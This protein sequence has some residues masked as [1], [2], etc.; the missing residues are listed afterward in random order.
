MSDIVR[1]LQ[2]YALLLE[3]LLLGEEGAGI[4]L[5]AGLQSLLRKILILRDTILLFSYILRA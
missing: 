2:A 1:T 3:R 5:V 4:V